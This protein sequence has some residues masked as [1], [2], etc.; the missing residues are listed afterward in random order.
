MLE[1]ELKEQSEQLSLLN[2]QINSTFP[3]ELN[4]SQLE[5]LSEQV[6]SE[7]P[8]IVENEITNIEAKITQINTDM[9]TLKSETSIVRQEINNINQTLTF[10]LYLSIGIS[11][12]VGFTAAFTIVWKRKD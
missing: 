3:V 7:L 5:E 12:A 6:S 4:E 2:E 9:N 8:A 10:V 1:R 11:I